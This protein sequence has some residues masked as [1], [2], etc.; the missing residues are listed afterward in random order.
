MKKE[1]VKEKEVI[2]SYK[3]EGYTKGEE[4]FNAVTHIVGAAFAVAMLVLGVIF[5]SINKDVWAVVSMAIY[6]ASMIIL[7]TTSSIYHFLP[8][9]KGKVVFRTLDHCMIFF[10]IAGTYTP[11]CLVTL[12]SV[13]AWGWIMFGLIWI[14][15]ALGITFNSI[16][17]HNKVIKFLTQVAYI[18]M[19]WCAMIAIVPLLK[20][21]ALEGFLWVL[22]GGLAYTFGAFFYWF[23]KKA[24]FIHSIWHLWVVL[25]S[26]LMFI[27]ILFYVIII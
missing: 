8:Q 7:F 3:F 23:G 15:A 14:L 22:G 26:I 13:G 27:G 17:M 4:I 19:G 9:N 5:A 24:K 21:F 18:A 1:I 20:V 12:R 2:P 25:G 16:N 11:I 6:G 10:L